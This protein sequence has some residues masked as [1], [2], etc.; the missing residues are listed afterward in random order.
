MNEPIWMIRFVK[1]VIDLILIIM[2]IRLARML[3]NSIENDR[4]KKHLNPVGIVKHDIW[5][6]F[7]GYI[8][9]TAIFFYPCLWT[10]NSHLIGPP[11]DNMQFFWNFW[12]AY[13]KV[14]HGIE[15][16][17]FTNYIYYPEGGS[18]SYHSWSFYNVAIAIPLRAVFNPVTTYNLIILQSFP[19]AG[20]GAFLFVRYLVGDSLLAF[21]GGFI[22]AFSPYHFAHAQHHV[23]IGSIQFI[24]FFVLYFIKAIREDS[25]ASLVLT[26]IFL[27]LNALCDWNYLI[28]ACFFMVF[29][30]VYLAA[31]RGRI[32]LRDVLWKSVIIT[33]SAVIFLLPFLWPMVAIKLKF[34]EGKNF[35]YWGKGFSSGNNG[36]ENFVA[37]ITGFFIPDYYHWLNHVG[38]IGRLNELYTGYAWERAVYLGLV[39]MVIVF[40]AGRRF[41]PSAAK[42]MLGALPFFILSLGAHPHVFGQSLPIPLP[43]RVLSEVPFLSEARVPARTIVYVYLFWG[44]IVVLALRQLIEGFPALGRRNLIVFVLF[45]LL[46]I[47]Y[48][49]MRLDRTEVIEPSWIS[50]ISPAGKQF[51]LL[52]LPIRG[53]Y[54]YSH[55]NRYMLDQTFHGVPIVQGQ[56]SRKIGKSFSDRLEIHDLE[57]L[58]QELIQNKVKYI[59]I[60]KRFLPDPLIDLDEFRETFQLVFEDTHAVVFREFLP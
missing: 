49:S 54:K 21:L 28:F 47:D 20:I 32:I 24:P 34:I 59:V 7:L 43:Y 14:L 1:L 18:L 8:L 56:T 35:L 13:N 52:N 27:I 9:L 30:Y 37:D 5:F 39:G 15:N 19:L 48:Y 25:K 50:V 45:G 60:H 2:L 58:K 44:V 36:F 10:F 46:F 23:N 55:I 26:S 17:G 38:F 6:A 57:R 41:L 29:S 53:Q 12:Y 33:G 22:F 11:E 3:F 40:V 16:L 51:G 4:S 31:R 42:Y